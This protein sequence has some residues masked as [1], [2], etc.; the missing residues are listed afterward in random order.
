[1][2]TQ[3]V[4]S[5]HR[6]DSRRNRTCFPGRLVALVSNKKHSSLGSCIFVI[7]SMCIHAARCMVRESLANNGCMCLPSFF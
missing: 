5:K 2:F 6:R 1:M 7:L 3:Q 4:G